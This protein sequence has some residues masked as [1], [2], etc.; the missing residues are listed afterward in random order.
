MY[1][2][3][4]EWYR[5][6]SLLRCPDGN[7]CDDVDATGLGAVGENPAPMWCCPGQWFEYGMDPCIC[8][9]TGMCGGNTLLAA[10]GREV[11]AEGVRVKLLV[12]DAVMSRRPWFPRLFKPYSAENRGLS[13]RDWRVPGSCKWAAIRAERSAIFPSLKSPSAPASAS[14][15]SFRLYDLRGPSNVLE[16]L[17]T[18][19]AGMKRGGWIWVMVAPVHQYLFLG[20]IEQWFPS[21][22]IAWS[23][24]SYSLWGHIKEN[25]VSIRITE[26]VLTLWALAA[27]QKLL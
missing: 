6:S 19:F 14:R 1:C 10:G 9:K 20:F 15:S 13:A 7:D 22:A 8:E 23:T 3:L 4:P 11:L 21:A 2:R 18:E 25:W 24:I 5:L 12:E 16:Y 26:G 17:S 27:L